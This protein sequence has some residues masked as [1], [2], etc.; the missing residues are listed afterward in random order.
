[1]HDANA[2]EFESPFERRRAG[3]LLHPTS[4][5]FDPVGGALGAE[6]RNFVDFLATMGAT[7]WQM[8]PLGPTHSDGSP[9]A[10]LSVFAGDPRLIS[11]AEL[12]REG[13]LEQVPA[14]GEELE[15][16]R[17]QCL[18]QASAGFAAR[19]DAQQRSAYD[20]F[21]EAQ[22]YW[23]ND[24]CLYQALRRRYEGRSWLDWPAPLRDRSA[25]ALRQAGDELR[26]EL[27]QVCFEQF[28]FDRQW[29]ALKS[30]AGERDVQ[31]FG[32]MPIFVAHDSAEVWARREL[33]TLDEHGQALT[34]AGVPPDYFSATGQRWGNPLYRWDRMG[35]DGFE[36][37]LRRVGHQLDVFD[38]V[39]IDHFR[40]FQAYWEIPAEAETAVDGQWVEAPG[41]ALFEAFQARFQPLP[42]VAEDLGLITP[43]VDALR[44]RFGLPGMK[45]L[46]F[47]FDGGATNPYLPHNHERDYVV[48][49]GTH[50]NSTTVGWYEGLDDGQRETVRAYLGYPEEAQPWP[51]IRAAL[52]SVAQ[53]CVLPMQDL[54]A[55][56]DSHRMNVPGVASGNW[57]WRFHWDMVDEDLAARMRDLFAL[58]GRLPGGQD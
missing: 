20:R 27:E 54:L 39:R 50:D 7:V 23:L 1:M 37:W 11:I 49:T 31:L 51:L 45:I 35:D 56:D 30:Y 38:F 6:A 44:H 52:A 2:A 40:G 12:Q 19:A 55:L 4:L 46:Q 15:Q 58:Y 32:D 34:V 18:Q 3:I 16:W 36:W 33:F 21:R 48:Y 26:A 43:E 41:E 53:M 25:E 13:W 22:A 5:P 24:Y 17:R 28:V 42:L 14:P 57:R 9:Y 10:C 47:A 29:R 8:L